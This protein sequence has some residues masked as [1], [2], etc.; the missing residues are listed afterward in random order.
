MDIFLPTYPPWIG[1]PEYLELLSISH[2][3]LLSRLKTHPSSLKPC[4]YCPQGY[5]LK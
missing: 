1:S 5:D 3:F 2:F 4:T